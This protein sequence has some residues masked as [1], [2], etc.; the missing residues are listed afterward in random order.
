MPLSMSST[1]EKASRK[2][3]DDDDTM[4]IAKSLQSW[5]DTNDARIFSMHIAWIRFDSEGFAVGVSAAAAMRTK[6]HNISYE[7]RGFGRDEWMI[8]FGKMETCLHAA[9]CMD[10]FTVVHGSAQL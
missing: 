3:S 4:R 9:R 5:I 1:V 2:R 6:V 10:V 8:G 7:M